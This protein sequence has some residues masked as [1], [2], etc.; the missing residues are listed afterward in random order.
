MSVGLLVSGS[1]VA[2]AALILPEEARRVP[3]RGPA[4]LSIQSADPSGTGCP[5][6][7]NI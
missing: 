4:H 6:T 1:A 5:S 2:A 7:Q 3:A